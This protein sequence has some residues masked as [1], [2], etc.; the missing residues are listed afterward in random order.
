[1]TLAS[2]TRW[3]ESSS[4][5]ISWRAGTHAT[6]VTYGALPARSYHEGLVHALLMDGSARGVSEN[7]SLTV[8]RS[9]GTRAG[10]ETVGEF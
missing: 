5:L 9:L 4:T 1:M 6:R 7:I 10:G 8:W 3:V 2:R